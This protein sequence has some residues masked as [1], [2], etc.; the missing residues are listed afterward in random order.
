MYKS[1]VIL[2]FV[3]ANISSGQEH[4]E[5]TQSLLAELK[6]DLT[7]QNVSDF[8]VVKHITFGTFHSFNRND[9]NSCI[10]KGTYFTMYAFWKKGKDSYIQKIDNCGRFN[11]ILLSDETPITYFKENSTTLKSDKVKQYQITPDSVVN[12]MIYGTFSRASHQPQRYF[13]FYHLS[14]EFTNHYDTYRTSTTKEEP[15]LNYEYNNN[16]S[17]VKLNAICEEI[18]Y[19]L[20]EKKKFNRL[21]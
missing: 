17:L 14:E 19:E 12:G 10:G 20:E 1:I 21:N 4:K 2:F 3:I 9:P 11:A 15:N 6:A 16:L 7:Q 5:V 13:W 8:F 18:I